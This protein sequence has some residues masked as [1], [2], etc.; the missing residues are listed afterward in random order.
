MPSPAPVRAIV[1]VCLVGG[2][3]L[4]PSMRAAGVGV[5]V[6][7]A[8]ANAPPA[9]VDLLIEP[10]ADGLHTTRVRV[11]VTDRNGHL[12]ITRVQARAEGPDPLLSTSWKPA[13]PAAADGT[14]AR[15][16]A[17]LTVP[18][19]ALQRGLLVVRA[20]VEDSGG[21]RVEATSQ[22]PGQGPLHGVAP[23]WVPAEADLVAD[24]FAPVRDLVLERVATGCRA[25]VC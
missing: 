13:R 16:V 12:D 15:Y 1:A 9:I 10:G 19:V 6:G 17:D 24:L 2:L 7:V 11:D 22:G 14:E 23:A 4:A 8:V 21:A 5:G 20:G 25:P 18:T 3:L